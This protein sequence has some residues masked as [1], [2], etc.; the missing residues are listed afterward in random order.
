MKKKGRRRRDGY[1]LE[2]SRLFSVSNLGSREISDFSFSNFR[3][4]AEACLDRLIHSRH[5]MDRY[6][7]LSGGKPA[8]GGKTDDSLKDIGKYMKS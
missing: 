7:T 6:V 2:S 8:K 4:A 5:H 3:L 1:F